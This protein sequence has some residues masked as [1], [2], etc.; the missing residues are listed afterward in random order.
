MV[1]KGLLYPVYA[2]ILE[3]AEQVCLALVLLFASQK[4]NNGSVLTQHFMLDIC[5]WERGR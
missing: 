3:E 2:S 1:Y 5:V 4:H